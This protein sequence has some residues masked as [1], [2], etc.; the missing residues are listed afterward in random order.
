MGEMRLGGMGWKR[1][2]PDF[3]DYTQDTPEVAEVLAQSEPLNF[4]KNDSSDQYPS[5]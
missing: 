4:V 3:R 1:D 5:I 2:L